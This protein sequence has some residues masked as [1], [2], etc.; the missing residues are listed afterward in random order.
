MDSF[1]NFLSENPSLA[2]VLVLATILLCATIL[3]LIYVALKDGGSIQLWKIKVSK[4]PK[5]AEGEA[6]DQS[7]AP[8]DVVSIPPGNDNWEEHLQESVDQFPEPLKRILANNLAEKLKKRIKEPYILLA[9]QESGQWLAEH[10]AVWLAGKH[11]IILAEKDIPQDRT[12]EYLE[13]PVK[14]LKVRPNLYIVHKELDQNSGSIVIV[15]DF[16]DG[17]G[18]V[19]S[20][21]DRLEITKNNVK[22]VATIA[23]NKTTLNELEDYLRENAVK[24]VYLLTAEGGLP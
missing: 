23:V 3:F 18:T 21:V 1:F 6:D 8:S 9:V 19:R 2:W 17:G 14:G 20:I 4:Q 13:I 10:L 7:C 11:T 24:L 16:I 15:D 22:A 12:G 5:K